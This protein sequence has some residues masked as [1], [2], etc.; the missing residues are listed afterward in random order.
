MRLDMKGIMNV[1]TPLAQTS[2]NPSMQCRMTSVFRKK[3]FFVNVRINLKRSLSELCFK[4]RCSIQELM[5][6]VLRL[7]DSVALWWLMTD[8]TEFDSSHY[9][10][11]LARLLRLSVFLESKHFWAVLPSYSFKQRSS[12]NHTWSAKWRKKIILSVQV[13]ILNHSYIVFRT[14]L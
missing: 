4:K 13:C 14:I 6:I 5:E 12:R 9:V 11:C 8:I 1:D 7:I 3:L 2:T 10:Y